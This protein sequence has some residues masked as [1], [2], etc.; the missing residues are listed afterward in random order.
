MAELPPELLAAIDAAKEQANR[1]LDQIA[2]DYRSTADLPDGHRFALLTR[3]V[4]ARPYTDVVG[5]LMLAVE[6]LAEA[7]A[8]P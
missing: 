7:P 5:L 6:R 2:A 4:G 8:R 3:L 1:E